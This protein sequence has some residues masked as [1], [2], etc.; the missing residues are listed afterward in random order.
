MSIFQDYFS[1]WTLHFIHGYDPYTVPTD[2]EIDFKIYNGIP[3]HEDKVVNRRFDHWNYS[4]EDYSIDSNSSALQ[5]LLKIITDGHIRASWAFRNQRATIFG[6][7]A[8]VCFTEASVKDLLKCAKICRKIGNKKYAIGLNKQELFSAGARPVIYGLTGEHDE[9]WIENAISDSWPRKL[10]QSSGLDE[11]EQYRYIQISP[12]F[13]QLIDNS[14]ERE[15]RW[16]DHDDRC[17][18]PGLPIWLSGEPQWFSKAFIVVPNSDD[19]N[20]VLDVLKQLYDNKSNG[21]EEP[22]SRDM[23]SST[24]VVALDRL[25]LE[26]EMELRDIQQTSFDDLYSLYFKGFDN[27]K[28]SSEIV[29][30]ARI[31]L[32]K[33]RNAADRAFDM[34]LQK[35]CRGESIGTGLY[36]WARLVIHGGHRSALVS[37][38]MELDAIYPIPGKGYYFR[39]ICS[40]DVRELS[41]A[42]SAAGGAKAVFESHFPEDS[43]SIESRLN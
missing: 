37:A 16:A 19:M 41:S 23:L 8:A 35:V 40:R 3:Y 42:E 14:H 12:H 22:F 9:K 29:R 24:T 32:E 4:D 18:C 25:D 34:H 33:A 26:E 28:P 6:P 36:G 17:G 2:N 43:F 27:S 31:V 21:I 20:Q 1:E 11:S 15:W 10:V 30:N 38:L 13:N 39:N 5:V 7:R